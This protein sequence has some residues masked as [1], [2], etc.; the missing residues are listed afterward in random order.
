MLAWERKR[1][2]WSRIN[3]LNIHPHI[4]IIYFHMCFIMYLECM[5]KGV[6]WWDLNKDNKLVANLH[7]KNPHQISRVLPSIEWFLLKIRD[8]H[9][10]VG[11]SQALFPSKM[12]LNHESFV[13]YRCLVQVVVCWPKSRPLLVHRHWL[14]SYPWS[15]GRAWLGSL[16]LLCQ[17]QGLVDSEEKG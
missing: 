15:M 3:V 6:W 4:I 10:V 1:E 5:F 16:G 11:Q 17:S 7:A 13:P 8:W 9:W 12:C 14:R 2:I